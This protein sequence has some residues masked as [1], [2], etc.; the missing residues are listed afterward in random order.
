MSNINILAVEDDPIYAETIRYTVEQAGYN[1][2]AIPTSGEEALK[3][4]ESQLPDLLLVDINLAG[5]MTGIEFAKKITKEIPIIFITSNT[6]RGVFEEVKKLRPVTFILKPFDALMLANNVELALAS[7]S[8]N[9]E[10]IWKKKDIILRDCFFVKEKKELIKVPISNIQ[11]IQSEDKYCTLHTLERKYVVRI[12]LKEFAGLLPDH[13]V[14][15]HRSYI[16][17]IALIDKINLEEFS[18]YI[19]QN[20]LPIGMAYKNQLIAS[21]R[22]I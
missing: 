20:D 4:M 12:P 17:D 15:I 5:K 8:G 9:K 3:I 7:T 10:D 2:I 6:E 1:M 22:R 21:L 19:G 11:F 14:Q 16:V 13:F 18:L